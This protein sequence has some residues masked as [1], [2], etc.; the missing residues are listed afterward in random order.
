M[1]CPALI[2][3]EASCLPEYGQSYPIEVALARIDGSS[4]TWLIRPSPK[5][6]FWDWSEEA[7]ALHGIS[8]EMLAREG[9]PPEQVLA[10]L[11]EVAGDCQVYADADLDAYWLEVLAGAVGAPVPFPVRYLGELLVERGYT[12]PQVVAA[13]A[14]AKARLPR[15]HVARDDASRLALTVRLL[16]DGDLP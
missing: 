4:R 10:E 2:D 7:E 14:E 8:R 13:L 16:L 1:S 5:W 9:L 3:F 11:A 6:R 12:R 15:E